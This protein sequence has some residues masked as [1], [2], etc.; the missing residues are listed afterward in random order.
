MTGTNVQ[1]LRENA[2]MKTVDQIVTQATV[3]GRC[4]YNVS[5]DDIFEAAPVD[6]KKH[7]QTTTH[8]RWMQLR[9]R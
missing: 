2:Q 8:Q 6:E 3:G 9:T 4:L 5:T 7:F 1:S